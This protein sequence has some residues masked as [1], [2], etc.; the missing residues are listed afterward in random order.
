CG[1]G[2]QQEPVEPV[3]E[4]PATELPMAGARVV[5]EAWPGGSGTP[6][7][8]ALLSQADPNPRLGEQVLEV[9]GVRA[10][11]PDQP[12]RVAPQAVGDR[13]AT[14]DPGSPP[15]GLEHGVRRAEPPGEDCSADQRVDHPP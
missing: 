13:C 11:S 8:R 5:V 6:A 4:V 12:E 1:E 10:V 7:Q 3:A 15:R 9:A 14:G 2:A